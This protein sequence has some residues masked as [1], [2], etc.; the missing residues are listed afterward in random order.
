VLTAV[1][2]D[3]DNSEDEHP[4]EWLADLCHRHGLDATADDLRRVPYII[5]LSSELR[6]RL[7]LG[8]PTEC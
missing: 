6:S 5:E 8:S 7:G 4:Y 2:P 3:D 1:V